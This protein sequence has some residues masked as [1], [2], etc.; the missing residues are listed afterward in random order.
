MCLVGISFAAAISACGFDHADIGAEVPPLVAR[1]EGT[2]P[3]DSTLYLYEPDGLSLVVNFNREFSDGEIRHVQLVPRPVRMG[4]PQAPA[5]N[6][7][8]VLIPG[9]VLDPRYSAYRLVL[10]G[11]AMSSPTVIS[12]YSQDHLVTEG[13]M[14]GHVRIARGRDEARDAIVYALAPAWRE[15]EFELTGAEERL[16]GRPVL[17]ATK[18]VVVPTEEGGWFRL[19]GLE[20]GKHYFVVSVLDTNRDGIY[21]LETDWWGYFRDSVEL[22]VEVEAGVWF[23]ALFEPPLPSLR[24]DVDFWLM[25]PGVLP[26][27]FD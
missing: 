2:S 6:P 5:S 9:V 22:A 21:D 24:D 3:R 20:L 26:A 7:R 12:Y 15:H 18:T 11:P 25:A 1:P 19:A 17:G 23:G 4:E 16:L 13:A 27:Q 10:D 8:Q 14:I